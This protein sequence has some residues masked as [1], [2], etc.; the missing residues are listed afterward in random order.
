MAHEVVIRLERMKDRIFEALSLLKQ[1]MADEK[2]IEKLEKSEE[3]QE[4]RYA[5]QEKAQET[6]FRG[7]VL[8]I[9]F[10]DKSLL[11]L[12]KQERW[13]EEDAIRLAEAVE[14]LQKAELKLYETLLGNINAAIGLLSPERIPKQSEQEAKGL[15]EKNAK[16]I[17][18][19]QEHLKR[20]AADEAQELKKIQDEQIEARRIKSILKQKE[21]DEKR[22]EGVV[23]LE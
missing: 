13:T 6:K 3:R 19:I 2:D 1:E 18:D 4:R 14:K 7:K 10:D 9:Y 17:K 5:R 21:Q 16:I 11:K 8:S 23:H 15:L 20:D 22:E 12:M